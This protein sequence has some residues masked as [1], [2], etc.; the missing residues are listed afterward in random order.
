MQEEKPENAPEHCP[1]TSSDKAGTAAACAGCP[2][3]AAC[4]SAPKGPDPDL[5]AIAE[6]LSTIKHKVLVLSGK[7]GVGKSTFAAQLAFALAAAGREVGLLDI[8][9]CG[10][11]A[12]KMLG[13]EGEEVHQSAL[14]WSPVYVE[15]NLAVMSIG[16]MLPNPDDAVIWRGPRKNALIK[17]FLKD[18][19]WGALDYLVVDAPPGTSDEHI[20]IAQFLRAGAPEAGAAAAPGAGAAAAG[21]SR[22]AAGGFDTAV[23]V[24]TPQ[25]VSIIDVRKEV[26]FCRKVGLSVLGVVE[27]M[28]GLVLP[29]VAAALRF[30]LPPAEAGGGGGG[31]GGEEEGEDVTARALAAI[32]A[33]LPPGAA[34]RLQLRAEVFTPSGGGAAAM[35]SQLGL[36][37]LGRVPLDPQLGRAAEEGRSV[38]DAAP[39]QQQ[40]GQ[41]QQDG[42]QNGPRGGAAASTPSAAALQAIVRRILA[43]TEA[44]AGA[45]GAAG[46]A[47]MD[48]A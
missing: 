42:E 36:T 13:L 12:P 5:V 25:E 32:A 46:R 41:Q 9:I 8:D 15:D 11:S 28:A 24:T 21:L 7:G 34:E 35:C 31:G 37:L 30:V 33:A 40:N 47:A 17:Q 26:S 3:Q 16:F 29:A 6:R 23:I 27:N 19:H 2:N 48:V 18:V 39:Q 45:S 10:P 38:F 20:S 43:V 4:A 14:G 22:N 44:D 1:G